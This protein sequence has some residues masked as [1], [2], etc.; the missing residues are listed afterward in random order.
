ML[1]VVIQAVIDLPSY[2]RL[3]QHDVVK[4]QV[5]LRRSLVI[6]PPSHRL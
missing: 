2:R 4:C 6:S 5:P 1:I 3:F